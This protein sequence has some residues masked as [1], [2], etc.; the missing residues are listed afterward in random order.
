MDVQ[1]L[2]QCVFTPLRNEGIE[3]LHELVNE[4]EVER[5]RN[6]LK[7]IRMVVAN[8][9]V[10]LIEYAA[11]YN[12]YINDDTN[13]L[14]HLLLSDGRHKELNNVTTKEMYT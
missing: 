1:K 11:S 10:G 4:E 6:R 13:D 12:K 8:L 14:S 7:R 9:L 5:D 2:I 3:K